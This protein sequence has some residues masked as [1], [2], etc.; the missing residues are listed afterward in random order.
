MPPRAELRVGKEFH[1]PNP[2]PLQQTHQTHQTIASITHHQTDALF[3]LASVPPKTTQN[4]V[5]STATSVKHSILRPVPWYAYG[6]R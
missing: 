6:A 2:P 3:T 5:R 1:P 4:Y